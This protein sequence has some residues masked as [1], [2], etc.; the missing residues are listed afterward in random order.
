MF[1][2]S[3]STIASYEMTSRTCKLI[4]EVGSSRKCETERHD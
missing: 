4:E 1:V 2:Q 3:F